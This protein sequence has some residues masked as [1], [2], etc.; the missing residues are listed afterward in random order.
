VP[1]LPV[2]KIQVTLRERMA[3]IEANLDDVQ[4]AAEASSR[5]ADT[6]IADT[7]KLDGLLKGPLLRSVGGHVKELKACVRDQRTALQELRN[8]V[9]RLRDELQVAQRADIRPPPL[10]AADREGS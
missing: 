1:F 5:A 3:A 7:T 4:A 9:A 6:L 8:S 10:A 2:E